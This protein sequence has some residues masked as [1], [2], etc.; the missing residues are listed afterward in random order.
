MLRLIY[1]LYLH[2]EDVGSLFPFFLTFKVR[3]PNTSGANTRFPVLVEH[4]I[5]V[6]FNKAALGKVVIECSESVHRDLSRSDKGE[7]K[8]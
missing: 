1:T 7:K 2:T 8:V 3:L 5:S 6:I 4:Y